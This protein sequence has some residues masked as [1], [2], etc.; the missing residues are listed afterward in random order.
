VA[1]VVQVG[2]V[3]RHLKESVVTG[4]GLGFTGV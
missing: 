3:V 1:R 4:G 2:V